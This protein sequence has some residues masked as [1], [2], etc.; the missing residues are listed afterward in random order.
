MSDAAA[1]ENFQ[2][3]VR[4][5]GDIGSLEWDGSVAES[6]LT[7]AV[8]LAADDALIAHGVR[9]LEVY[10]AAHDD[11]ARR[12]VQRAGF[13]LEGVRRA[14][15]QVSPCEFADIVVYSRLAS[16]VVYGSEGFTAT[17][18]AVLPRK[19]CMAHVLFRNSAGK[20]LF[21]QQTYKE[22]WELPGGITEPGESPRQ[23][24]QREVFE[25]LGIEVSLSRLLCIDW[26]APYL[27]WEDA[28]AFIFDGGVLSNE[29]LATLEIDHHEIA[30]IVWTDVATAQQHLPATFAARLPI[31][32]E[33]LNNLDAATLYLEQG[34]VDSYLQ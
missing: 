29:Q 4:L 24:A 6:T 33:L 17:L 1:E 28:V 31:I 21:C 2:I 10:L 32:V 5:N 26:L 19:R 12:S 11:V 7:E 13:R 8:S 25:E 23:G 20:L 9:R 16:D 34:I 14:A 15:L 3:S 22:D 18:N 30:N 27:G